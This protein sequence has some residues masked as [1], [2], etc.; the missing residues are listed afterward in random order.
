[1][2]ASTPRSRKSKGM[3]FQKKIVEMILQFFPTLTEN[4]VRSI[5]GSVPGTDIWLSEEA[6]KQFPYALEAK[7]TEKLNIW[8]AI[9]QA[10]QNSR[11]GTPVVVFKRNRSD[12]YCCLKFNDFLK[13]TGDKR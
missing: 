12:I 2:T 6:F 13:L 1:V 5:P 9:E 4:D 10:E 3:G 8:S 11:K 7:R